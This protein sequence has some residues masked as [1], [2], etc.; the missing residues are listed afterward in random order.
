MV[1]VRKGKPISGHRPSELLPTTENAVPE[2]KFESSTPE[3]IR[4]PPETGLPRVIAR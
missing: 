2:S 4:F 1:A 3:I